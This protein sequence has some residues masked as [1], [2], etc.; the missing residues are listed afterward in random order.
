M[1]RKLI[2]TYTCTHTHTLMQ[3]KSEH[4]HTCIHTHIHTYIHTFW[5]A[6]QDLPSAQDLQAQTQ[7]HCACSDDDGRGHFL[8][9]VCL[10]VCISC[11]FIHVWHGILCVSMVA[12]NYDIDAH[13]LINHG[14]SCMMLC[15]SV[16]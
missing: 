13:V 4:T 10:H 5:D 12:Q 14:N 7:E 3:R 1:Q 2:D 16:L 15:M 8:P 11:V 6:P 9:A